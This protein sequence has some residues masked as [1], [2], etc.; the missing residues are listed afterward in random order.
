[1]HLAI[2]ME[3]LDQVICAVEA[4]Q[5]R[6]LAAARR[7]DEAG[8]N[9]FLQTHEMLFDAHSHAFR[10]LGGV[11]KRGIYDNMRTAVDKVGRGKDRQ[12]NAR[13]LA[14]VSHYLFDAGFLQSGFWL[15]KGASREERPGRA[16][17]AVAAAAVLRRSGR[18]ERVAGTALR[19]TMG[20][21]P[22]WSAARNHRRCLGGGSREPHAGAA[23]V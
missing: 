22:A 5:R 11:P 4:A 16:S 17:S 21:N 2:E 23:A 12:V 14:M 18:P 20:A 3:A 8:D 15:G 13:F 6:D 19:R 1:M 10:V 7:A 9:A